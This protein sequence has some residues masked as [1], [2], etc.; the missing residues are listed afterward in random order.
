VVSELRLQ[1]I[2]DR[3]LEELSEVLL[4]QISDPR[5]TGISV[6]DVKVD[7]EMSYADIYVSAIEGSSRAQ[8]VLSGLE[9]AQG[10]LR[11]ELSQRI[12]LR[13]FPRLRFHW[14]VTF[15]RADRIEQLIASLHDGRSENEPD[16]EL[17]ASP[18][19]EKGKNGNR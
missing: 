2:A 5:L 13:Y 12:E 6:T 10:Y 8:D 18:R 16:S 11:H 4:K 3:I 1:R 7:R 17:S 9:H 15:E 14:D 19:K